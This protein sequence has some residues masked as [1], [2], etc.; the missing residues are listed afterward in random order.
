MDE[1]LV[2]DD[3]TAPPPQVWLYGTGSPF[4]LTDS[5]WHAMSGLTCHGAAPGNS[6]WDTG[7]LDLQRIHDSAIEGTILPPIDPP[8]GED[9]DYRTVKNVPDADWARNII[10]RMLCEGII[11][12]G[13]GTDWEKP[14]KNGTVFNYLDRFT[15]AINNGETMDC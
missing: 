4:R 11:A 5:E 2:G 1:G 15:N 13:D 9:M 14:L 3:V 10:D 6:H 7:V 8:P 12:E